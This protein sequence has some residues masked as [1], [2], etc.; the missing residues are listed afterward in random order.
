MPEL[1][2][3]QTI[4]VWAIPVLFA[5]TLHEVAHGWVALSFGDRTAQMLGRLSLNP[6]RH[7]DPVGTVI[8]PLM[9]TL[10]KTG[11]L[12]GWAKPVPVNYSNLKHPKRDM[13]IVALAGPVSNLLMLIGWAAVL[14]ATMQVAA[15]E[16]VVLGL[17]YMAVA[18][19]NINIIL[20]VLNML[21]LPPLD[22]GRVLTGVLPHRA[23]LAFSRIEPFGFVILILMMISG[24]LGAVLQWPMALCYGLTLQLFGIDPAM[25]FSLFQ[26]IA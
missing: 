19:I 3:M 4:A 11:F 14:K 26:Q 9:L 20:M 6:V 15:D 18:G 23:A 7:I 8:L 1:N 2:L 24:V 5:I 21:P 13:A 25:F 22:G 12:F 16:G 17:R 10:M